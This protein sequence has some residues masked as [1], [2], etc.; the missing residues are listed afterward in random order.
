MQTTTIVAPSSR[1]ALE[2]VA[3]MFGPDAIVYETRTTRHGV[4]VVAGGIERPDPR[5]AQEIKTP[6]V[7]TPAPQPKGKDPMVR[8]IAQSRAVGIDPEFLTG[9][10]A[11]AGADLADAW[12]RFLIRVEREV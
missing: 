9:E 7:F 1:I 8:F 11:A 2:R 5:R 4:E 10:M 6:P 12:S 3:E